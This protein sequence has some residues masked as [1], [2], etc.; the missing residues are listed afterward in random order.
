MPRG[1]PRPGAGA[2]KGNINAF[3]HGA[4]SKQFKALLIHL[5]QDPAF[6][7]LVALAR[8]RAAMPRRR[9]NPVRGV[10]LD[11][12]ALMA[13][14]GSNVARSRQ[15]ARRNAR[16]QSRIVREEQNVCSGNQV[17]KIDSFA[18]GDCQVPKPPRAA[19]ASVKS[20]LGLKFLKFIQVALANSLER[21]EQSY[22][23]CR[24][25]LHTPWEEVG[26]IA[27]PYRSAITCPVFE[28]S[29]P[30]RVATSVGKWGP[31]MMESSGSRRG[32]S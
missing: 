1:G 5:M 26:C 16:R 19:R 32:L 3:K 12:G 27:R 24:G 22:N 18:S 7:Y 8:K 28:V 25:V 29:Y 20:R 9:H 6:I 30:P 17:Q 2:P 10:Q 14:T 4:S 23:R 31:R 11:I 13:A 21:G 15:Y